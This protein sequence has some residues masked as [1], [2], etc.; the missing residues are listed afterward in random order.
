MQFWMLSRVGP[1]NHVLDESAHWRNLANT[2]E[3]SACGGDAALR[4]ITL[5]TR[6]LSVCGSVRKIR[7]AMRWLF[8]TRVKHSLSFRTHCT[9]S[10]RRAAKRWRFWTCVRLAIC[11][12]QLSFRRRKPSLSSLSARASGRDS[13]MMDGA[14]SWVGGQNLSAP[15]NALSRP[16][17]LLRN[18]VAINAV[19]AA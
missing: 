11:T 19:N 7:L 15:D 6:F 5:T 1:G 12:R 4:Q 9:H 3:S 10:V 17:N 2:I 16:A 18:N 13:R 8:A 14:A